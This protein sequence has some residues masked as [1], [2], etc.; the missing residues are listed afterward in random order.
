[1]HLITARAMWGIKTHNRPQS[2]TLIGFERVRTPR[3][4]PLS[5]RVRHPKVPPILGCIDLLEEYRSLRLW[6][7]LIYLGLNPNRLVHT[8]NHTF[9]EVTQSFWGVARYQA[10]CFSNIGP[11]TLATYASCIDCSLC[12]VN[13]NT[14]GEEFV[15]ISRHASMQ[16]IQA[17]WCVRGA[18]DSGVDETCCEGMPKRGPQEISKIYRYTSYIAVVHSNHM[19]CFPNLKKAIELR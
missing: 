1:M 11:I 7:Y 9:T 8:R 13:P 2:S 5:N 6:G 14:W 17:A 10:K 4:P 15:E 12:S 16:F 3:R 18:G 19:S